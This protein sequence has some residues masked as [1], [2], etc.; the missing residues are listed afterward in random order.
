MNDFFVR[1]VALP[2]AIK[3]CMLP[4][5]DGT[6]SIYINSR[7]STFEQR[8]TLEHELIHIEQDDLYSLLPIEIIEDNAEHGIK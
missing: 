5:D 1:F 7:I 8:R 6:Y 4:N 3:G 2:F